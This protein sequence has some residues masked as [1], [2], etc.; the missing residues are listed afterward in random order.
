ME[1]FIRS[2]GEELSL[3]A[4]DADIIHYKVVARFMK[5][6]GRNGKVLASLALF[7]RAGG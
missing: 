2:R 7:L 6:G 4:V 1:A 3:V 5:G